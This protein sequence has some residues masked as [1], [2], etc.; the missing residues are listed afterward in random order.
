M[1]QLVGAICKTNITH[2]HVSKDLVCKKGLNTFDK[3]NCVGTF[4]IG[5]T[6]TYCSKTCDRKRRKFSDK[7]QG[8]LILFLRINLIRIGN[9]LSK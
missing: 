8:Q 5:K 2:S 1:G 6:I 7:S 4:F 9:I 3:Y